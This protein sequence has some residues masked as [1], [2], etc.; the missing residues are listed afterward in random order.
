VELI[1]LLF[2]CWDGCEILAISESCYI[3]SVHMFWPLGAVSEK[4]HITSK[5]NIFGMIAI[6][7]NFH[8]LIIKNMAFQTAKHLI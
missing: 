3:P 8:R 2:F 5:R 4:F 6:W 7:I 1:I